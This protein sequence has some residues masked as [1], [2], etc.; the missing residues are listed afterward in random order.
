MIQYWQVVYKLNILVTNHNQRNAVTNRWTHR[1]TYSVV[2][3]QC[4]SI[5]YSAINSSTD[6]IADIIYVYW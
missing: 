2:R 6:V 3:M 4:Y 5:D 1:C